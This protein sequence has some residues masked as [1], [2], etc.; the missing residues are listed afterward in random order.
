MEMTL[1]K[2]FGTDGIRGVANQ[3]LTPELVFRVGR[4]VGSILRKN[5]H[6]EILVGKDPRVS[7]DMLEGALQS[8]ILSVGASVCSC[9]II[10][11]PA[12]S[13]LTKSMK[14]KAGIMISA[15]H[16][17]LEHNGIKI[18]SSAGLKLSDHEENQIESILKLKDDK[19]KRPIGTEV[20][21]LKILD[22][23]KERYIDYLKSCFKVSLKGIRLVLDCAY[24]SAS[25]I[26]PVLF[27]SLGAKVILKCST[28]NGE[29]INVSCG[30]AFPDFLRKTVIKEKADLGIAFDGDADRVIF[31]T[32]KGELFHGDHTLALLGIHWFK[33]K[34]L[35]GP[36]VTTVMSNFGLEKALKEKNIKLIRTQIGDRYVLEEMLKKNANLG[37]EQSGHLILLNHGVSGDGCLTALAVL[38]VLRETGRSLSDFQKIIEVFPQILKNVPVRRKNYFHHDEE[39][40]KILHEQE[41]R[42]KGK[43]RLVVRP[44]GTEPLIRIM[45]EGLDRKELEEVVNLLAYSIE[46][47]LK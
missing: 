20:G 7:S 46:R 19:L 43:G 26:A 10:P 28:P 24:G 12:V 1:K 31:V 27:E 30:A 14:F 25:V 13:Y 11:T 44:S 4:A 33:K 22:E 39:I 6:G 45:A 41:K 9:G 21:K 17:P 5:G 8:G 18:F 29:K 15:S 3:D 34:K 38:S 35:K 32:G 23:A 2:Y 37:G 47:R 36:V 16:N 42:L 40:Q